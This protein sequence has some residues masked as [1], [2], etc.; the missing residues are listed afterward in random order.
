MQFVEDYLQLQTLRYGSRLHFS[1]ED[2][3]QRLHKIACPPLLLQ[4][5]VENAIRHDLDTHHENSDIRLSFA[6]SDGM[7]GLHSAIHFTIKAK[8]LAVLAWDYV[9]RD[10]LNMLYE[11]E[12]DSHH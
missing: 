10:R 11:F 1:C 12:G 5:M 8:A 7:L 2:L 3:R 9:T 6:I 4:P